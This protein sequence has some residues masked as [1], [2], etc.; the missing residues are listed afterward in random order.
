MFFT[1]IELMMTIVTNSSILYQQ[2]QFKTTMYQ[3]MISSIL[4]D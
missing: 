4:G 2:V 1:F 3:Y